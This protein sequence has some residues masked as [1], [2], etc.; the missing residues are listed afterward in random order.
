MLVRPA[1]RPSFVGVWKKALESSPTQHSDRAIAGTS[2]NCDQVQ[3][4]RTRWR[5][6]YGRIRTRR[7]CPLYAD[8]IG[9]WFLF[10]LAHI[11]F[12]EIASTVDQESSDGHVGETAAPIVNATVE[13]ELTIDED[14]LR[15]VREA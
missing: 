3:P 6:E 14:F 13:E 9:S 4:V 15:R 12:V 11:R 1:Y 10:P 5:S 8:H 2:A 7:H